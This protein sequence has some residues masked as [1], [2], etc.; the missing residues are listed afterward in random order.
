MKLKTSAP[1]V[2]MSDWLESNF[3]VLDADGNE[4]VTRLE[5]ETLIAN[6]K[7]HGKT[8]VYLST[9]HTNIAYWT[10]AYEL[11][12]VEIN[13]ANQQITRKG[14]KKF[15][16]SLAREEY[17]D[18]KSKEFAAIYY[19]GDTYD[20]QMNRLQA[21]PYLPDNAAYQCD[22]GTCSAIAPLVSALNRDAHIMDKMI[23]TNLAADGSIL[24]Y[25]VTFSGY[26]NSITVEPPTDAE[27]A[28]YAN[29]LKAAIVEKAIA[30]YVSSKY[31]EQFKQ[32]GIPLPA[33][34]SSPLP[35]ERIS[36]VGI[37]PCL[38]LQ[39]LSGENKIVMVDIGKTS[40]QNLQQ[41]L[42]LAQTN[43]K[44][45]LGRTP[46]RIGKAPIKD[47]Q[48]HHIYSCVYTA[49][50]KTVLLINPRHPAYRYSEPRNKDRSATDGKEDS[51]FTV[52]LDYFHKH[53]IALF[54]AG[55]I[56]QG[57]SGE[58]VYRVLLP[59]D[60]GQF[61]TDMDKDDLRVN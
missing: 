20:Q 59:E 44:L 38:A 53:F 55:D 35:I 1:L 33:E 22:A 2:E 17:L 14:I 29:G 56:T 4:A 41:L 11:C 6:P 48:P 47:L 25:D 46:R 34:F 18:D 13:Y 21:L 43:G 58:I 3:T 28:H 36:S 57:L 49:Q 42:E 5:L 61:L 30:T 23:K 52:S 45:I 32:L 50:N 27:L 26:S 7:F 10:D 39:L 12:A 8:A 51:K 15:N 37:D 54:I 16:Q 9:L 40:K 24:S 31:V 60:C 19:L